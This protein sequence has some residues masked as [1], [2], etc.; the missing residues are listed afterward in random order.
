MAKYEILARQIKEQIERGIWL[1]N[2]KLPSLRKQARQT[3][4]SL[5]TVLHAYQMLESQGLISSHERS[6][7]TVTATAR[8]ASENKVQTAEAVSINDFVSK[9]KFNLGYDNHRTKIT[10]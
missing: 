1:E 5:M 8:P 10:A 4:Y 3:G 6:G 9:F 2:E 7:F